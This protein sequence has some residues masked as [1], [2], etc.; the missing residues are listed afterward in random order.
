M[1]EGFSGT[2]KFEF[3]GI[4]SLEGGF[5]IDLDVNKPWDKTNLI[6]GAFNGILPREIA[7]EECLYPWNF[8]GI[9][10]DGKV[11][12]GRQLSIANI[13]E[14]PMSRV[15]LCKFD[16]TQLTIGE[17]QESEYIEFWIPN[18]VIGFDETSEHS[19]GRMLRDKTYLN[20]NFK[21]EAFSL[22]F[23]G[24][25]DIVINYNEA[26]RREDNFISVKVIVKKETGLLSYETAVELMDTLL[27]LYSIAYGCRLKW[28]NAIGYIGQHEIFHHI[29]KVPPATLRPFRQLIDV[30]FHNKLTHFIETCFPVYSTFSNDTR[31]A[32]R[33]LTDGI[34]LSASMPIFPMPFIITG[35]TIEEFV[36]NELGDVDVN[37]ITRAD[38]RRTYSYF[39]DLMEEHI[40]PLLSEEDSAELMNNQ[41]LPNQWKVLFQRNLRARIIKLLQEYNLEF[42]GEHLKNFVNKR[43]SAAHGGY[44][45]SPSDYIV[46]SKMVAL[47]EQVLLKKLKYEGEYIDYSTNPPAP[48]TLSINES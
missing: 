11:I 5:H 21:Q 15:Y 7:N 37:Y 23:T 6:K 45:F 47:L 3:D 44:E 29:R 40:N 39:K 31:L 12:S 2:G 33:K 46:W 42:N 10:T 35:S 41:I 19:P 18:F 43:N 17:S 14:R 38:R 30:V 8:N 22:E 32:L 26:L 34:H 28:T 16:F 13:K 9:T 25:Q 27:D 36:K 24:V 4:E 48:K 20:L 1:S